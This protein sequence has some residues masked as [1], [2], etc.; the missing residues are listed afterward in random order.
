M[1]LVLTAVASYGADAD[2]RPVIMLAG[3]SFAVADN[4]WFEAACDDLG[5]VPL[6]KSRSGEAIYNMARR[7]AAGTLYTVAELDDTDLLVIDHVH[8][9]NV[10][11]ERKLEESWQDYDD[12]DTSTDY[13]RA[14]DY[15]IK[16]YMYDCAALR[17]DW[18]SKYYGVTG[19]K[20]VRIA[21]CTHWHDGRTTYNAAV[22][23]LAERWHVSLVEF[24]RE[25]GFSS[26]DAAGG[27]QPSVAQAFD[28]EVINGEVYGWHP[29]RGSNC[30]VQRR[31]A[32]IFTG[33]AA[34]VLGIDVPFEC[35]LAAVSPM[36]QRGEKAV[37]ML[38]F[39]GGNYPFDVVCGGSEPAEVTACPQLIESEPADGYEP[40]V[41]G[42]E[43]VTDSRGTVAALPEP[44]AVDVAEYAITP[45]FDAHVNQMNPSSTYSNSNVLQL[46]SGDGDERKIVLTFPIDGIDPRAGR[47]AVRMF[48]SGYALG[49]SS[50]G[51]RSV[52]GIETA[53]ISARATA[54]A[55]S[56]CWLTL[57]DDDFEPVGS[58]L[59]TKDMHLKW[60]GWDVTDW[61]REQVDNGARH[62][63][64]LIR[65]PSGWRLRADFAS[66]DNPSLLRFAPQMLVGKPM[67]HNAVQSVGCDAVEVC[68]SEVLNPSALPLVITSVSGLVLY[69][70]RDTA[71]NMS[72]YPSGIYV[73]RAGGDTVIKLAI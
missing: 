22:R 10:A 12:V 47:V 11:D 39:R 46:K 42:V 53:R 15:V 13:A 65:V 37:A 23:L 17:F 7:M 18:R 2:G 58:T 60:V 59:L 68:G 63:S 30:T 54:Y 28:R 72:S 31:M 51:N 9:R 64:F 67:A 29:L 6:N 14:F 21:L 38:T 20:P 61:V 43:S 41:F 19:G 3:A 73:V 52:N 56:L 36:V 55:G 70:G 40:V 71:V 5:A 66:A 1:A 35:S 27:E 45:T 32:Q 16:R 33:V 62:A 25:I 69:S 4:G 50:D 49:T 44:M 57:D 34:R 48:M 24:D 8:D 26:A